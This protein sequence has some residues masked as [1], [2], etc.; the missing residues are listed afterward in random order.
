MLL[1]MLEDGTPERR[2]ML[3]TPHL[4]VGES[5]GARRGQPTSAYSAPT[6]SVLAAERR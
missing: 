5:T 4:I 3:V 1:D 2:Q 6:R